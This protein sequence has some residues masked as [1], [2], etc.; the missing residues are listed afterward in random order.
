[1]KII[2]AEKMGF[3]FGVKNAIDTCYKISKE[4]SKKYILG[5]IVHNK[6]VVNDMKST[7]FEVIEEENI[8][9]NNNSLKEGDTI[10]IRAHGTT[11]D[12]MDILNSKKINII[13]TTCVFVKKIK[14]ILIEQE[15]LGDHIIFIGDKN[16]PEVRGIIS[17]G[18][19]VVVFKNLE[20]LKTS[21]FD[22]NIS[23]TV[24]TQTTLNKEKFFKIKNFLE[25]K[26]KN[27]K[28]FDKICGATS[29]RQ[30]ATKNLSKM[31]DI[32]LVIGDEKSSNSKKLLEIAKT[33]NNNSFLIQ[34][35]KELSLELLKNIEIVG[36]TAGASTPEKIIKNI[37]NKIRGNFDV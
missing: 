31:A 30:E 19:N 27:M 5:M 28:I 25:K 4:N 10:I 22:Y 3:C 7:G 16:H 37:E 24:L 2:R 11:K 26:Y 23:Y 17:F 35:E 33:Y 18:K 13:D 34:N 1:M 6:D 20:E 36:I 15:K 32:V 12:I 9:N 8:L 21:N 29:E 14:K